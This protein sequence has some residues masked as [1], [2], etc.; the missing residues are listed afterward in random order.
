MKCVYPR[1]LTFGHKKRTKASP[2]QI[3]SESKM[4]S[5]RSQRLKA[6]HYGISIPQMY[7]MR[8]IHRVRK[9]VSG[10]LELMGAGRRESW[11]LDL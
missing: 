7:K 10:G 2:V 1:G 5:E 3:N 4:F 11:C 8:Q 6:T 9:W